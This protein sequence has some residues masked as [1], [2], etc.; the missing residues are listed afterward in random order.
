MKFSIIIPA[1][2]A[3]STI[4]KTL[5]SV[6]S[7]DFKDYEVIVVCDSCEDNTEEVAKSYGA[8][9]AVVAAETAAIRLQEVANA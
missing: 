5:E 9:T 6:R 7:Q 1:H 3:G 2:N 8:I 4:G